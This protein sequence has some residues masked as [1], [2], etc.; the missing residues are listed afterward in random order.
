MHDYSMPEKCLKF[1]ELHRYLVDLP[2]IELYLLMDLG[3][4]ALRKRYA[5]RV[6]GRDG[7]KAQN[8]NTMV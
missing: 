6:K 3:P 1:H 2:R 8:F 5:S 7:N 4:V